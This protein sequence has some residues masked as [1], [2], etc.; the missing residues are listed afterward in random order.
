MNVFGI[1][2]IGFNAANGRKLVLT[3][4]FVG[5]ALLLRAIIIGMA[6]VLTGEHRNDRVMFWTRPGASIAAAV[7]AIVAEMTVRFIVG[8]HGTREV[9]DAIARSILKKFTAASIEVAST[10]VEVVGLPMVKV[11]NH[12]AA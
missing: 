11:Q 2:M 1:P 9:K 5:G 8:D 7:L 10:T 6:R 12:A 3:I 4:A